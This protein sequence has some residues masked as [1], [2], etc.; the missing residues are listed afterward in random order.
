MSTV[1]GRVDDASKQRVSRMSRGSLRAYDLYLHARAAQDRN[2]KEDYAQ[3]ELLLEQAI[4]VDPTFAQAHRDL[5][6]VKFMGWM[7][8]WVDER[9]KTFADALAT[10]KYAL[11]LDENDSELHCNLGLIQVFARAY[12]D[13]GLHLEKSIRLNPNNSKA[14]SLYGI[15]LTAIDEPER[16]LEQFDIAARLNPLEPGWSNWLKGIARFTAGRYDEAIA[17]FKSIEKP[18]NEVRGWLAASFGHAGRLEEARLTLE[19]FLS[20]AESEMT[21]FPGR[22]LAQWESY[23]HC[24]LEYKSQSNFEHLFEGLRMAGLE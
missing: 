12:E 14:F 6:L 23:W 1:G 5:S 2:T 4:A 24:A 21:I 15:Y 8:H 17:T 11:G 16:A 10:A 7:A 3:A 22:R 20:V 9:E 19:E 18:I 13:A